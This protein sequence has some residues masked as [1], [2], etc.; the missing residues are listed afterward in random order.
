M[1]TGTLAR[2][3]RKRANAILQL[4]AAALAAD[5]RRVHGQIAGACGVAARDRDGW[6]LQDFDFL[7]QRRLSWKAPSS[8]VAEKL[9][10]EFAAVLSRT[11]LFSSTA[12]IY[13]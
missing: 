4:I 5:R 10:S 1:V 6:N 13:C 7:K 2:Y 9:A 3:D 8:T 12:A 11:W